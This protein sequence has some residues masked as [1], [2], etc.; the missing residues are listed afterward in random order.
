MF[1]VKIYTASVEQVKVLSWGFNI[2]KGKEEDYYLAQ[3]KK[4]NMP[5]FG[6]FSP[7]ILFLW[8]E[9]CSIFLV[10]FSVTRSFSSPCELHVCKCAHILWSNSKGVFLVSCVFQTELRKAVVSE[11]KEQFYLAK[12]TIALTGVSHRNNLCVSFVV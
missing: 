9:Q 5:G 8:L 11:Y 2:S 4:K 7:N 1:I 3:K 6:C 10:T 12:H